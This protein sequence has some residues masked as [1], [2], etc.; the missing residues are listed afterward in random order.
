MA[1]QLPDHTPEQ[2]EA[3]LRTHALFDSTVRLVVER[4]PL[5]S[6][7]YY[8]ATSNCFH[9][10]VCNKSVKMV[11]PNLAFVNFFKEARGKR[12]VEIENVDWPKDPPNHHAD[13][14]ADAIYSV[15]WPHLPVDGSFSTEG[16]YEAKILCLG[17]KLPP[18]IRCFALF[19]TYLYGAMCSLASLASPVSL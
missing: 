5:A 10:F 7:S 14:D 3:G 16:D 15:R 12:V 19:L 1:E 18:S 13:F 8:C 17:G 11:K 9:Y 4:T 6:D 2:A